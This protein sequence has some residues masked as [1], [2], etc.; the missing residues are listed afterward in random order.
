M[1]PPAPKPD[2][3]QAPVAQVQQEPVAEV[4]AAEEEPVV[5]AAEIEQPVVLMVKKAAPK[6]DLAKLKQNAKS[7]IQASILKNKLLESAAQ[8]QPMSLVA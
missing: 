7:L 8:P 3:K 1:T 4:V 6:V 2:S 5:M